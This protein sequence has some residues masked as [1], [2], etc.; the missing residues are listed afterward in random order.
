MLVLLVAASLINGDSK[1]ANDTEYSAFKTVL[2]TMG[3][4]RKYCELIAF[5]ALTTVRVLSSCWWCRLR[6]CRVVFVG[7]VQSNDA[8]C[9]VEQLVDLRFAQSNHS[10]VSRL[11]IFN[12]C[13]FERCQIFRVACARSSLFVAAI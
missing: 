3:K 8:V 2:N 5:P 12:V 11:Y 1:I 4:Q 7:N 6:D 10:A 9:D 13:R